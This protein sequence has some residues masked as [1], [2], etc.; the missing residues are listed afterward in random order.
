M[1]RW[2]VTRRF[3]RFLIRPTLRS[4]RGQMTRR[5]FSY[6]TVAIIATPT[7]PSLFPINTAQIYFLYYSPSTMKI[8]TTQAGERYTAFGL[9][10]YQILCHIRLHAPFHSY[11]GLEDMLEKTHSADFL[12]V[13][14]WAYSQ[15]Q[16]SEHHDMP[17]QCARNTSCPRAYVPKLRL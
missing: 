1:G 6:T 16:P 9:R 3:K 8:P 12:Y 4:E 10:I 17:R 11:L 14:S 2:I 5:F 13:R 7:S 15:A